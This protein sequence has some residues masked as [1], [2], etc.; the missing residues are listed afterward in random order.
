MSLDLVEFNPMLRS[1]E[2]LNGLKSAI[3]KGQ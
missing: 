3:V 2:R 1:L